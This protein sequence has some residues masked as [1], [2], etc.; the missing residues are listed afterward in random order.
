MPR[1]SLHASQ[2]TKSTAAGKIPV[3]WEC[4]RLGDLVPEDKPIVYGIVQAGP[5]VPDGVPYIR[6]TEVGG[7][8]CADTLLK[9][10][11]EIAKKYKRSVVSAGDIVFSLRGNIGELSI[12]PPELGGA[13]LTQG[14]AR[15]SP[16]KGYLAGFIKHSLHETSTHRR[17]LAVAKGST[18]HEITLEDLRG[19]PI[20]VPPLG[21]QQKIADILGTWDEALDKFD[22]L[23]A[24]KDSRK[25]ALM[26]QLLRVAANKAG[27]GHTRHRLGNVVERVTRRNTIDCKTVL[28]ISAQDGLIDQREYFNRSVAGADLSGYYLLY[29]GEF[30]YNRSSS[31]GY[32]YGALKRLDRYDNGVVSTL[33]LC[34]RIR[35]EATVSADYLSHYFDGGY[36]N[37]G[38]RSVAKEGARAH[39]L[40]NVTADE[41]MELDIFLPPLP[42]Q[43]QIADVLDAADAELRLLR[44]QRAALDHQK[45]GLMQQLLTGRIRVAA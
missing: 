20:A 7:T 10:S 12:V 34:F 31:I 5:H 40:L 23:I 11:P 28:T 37:S 42:L 45:R 38:L 33:Y 24:A 39:G 17:I 35:D 41:F 18:F 26:Q 6:S 8:I 13:N 30:A 15:I 32:P 25:Q 21:E 3:D 36:L 14:T 2:K 1:L 22:G 44:K 29:R 43:T 19:L 4:A 9:T 27:H 16:K